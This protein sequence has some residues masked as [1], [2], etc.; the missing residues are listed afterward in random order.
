M[1][2]F[3]KTKLELT[4][5]GMENRPRLESRILLEDSEKSYYV[6]H[7]ATDRDL[8]GNRL[9]FGDNLLELKAIAREYIGKIKCTYIGPPYN[10]GS[11]IEHCDDWIEHSLWMSLMRGR[12][13]ILSYLLA[14]AGA[15][16]INLDDNE[17]PQLAKLTAR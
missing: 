5:I 17:A 13:E 4:W 12:L 10:T 8:F 15:I 7:R 9:I 3:K 16:W 6:T 1:T 14:K 11:A 2:Q